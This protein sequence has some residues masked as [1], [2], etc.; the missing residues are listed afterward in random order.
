VSR[1]G[2]SAAILGGLVY[3]CGGSVDH[4]VVGRVDVFD[5]FESAWRQVV[6]LQVPRQGASAC[7]VNHRLYICGGWDAGDS[8]LSSVEGL[9]GGTEEAWCLEPFQLMQARSWFGSGVLNNELYFCGGQSKHDPLNSAERLNLQTGRQEKLPAMRECRSAPGSAAIAGPN[10]PC[11]V[12]AG[13]WDQHRQNLRTVELFDPRE[14]VWTSIVPLLS[15]RFGAAACSVE[16]GLV[17]LGGYED[18]DI[19]A[20]LNTTERFSPSEQRWN[21]L[22]PMLFARSGAVAVAGFCS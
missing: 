3:F 16:G 8:P 22:S 5:P 17:V 14:G 13:G 10:G 12:V 19:D 6:S 20:C 15:R 1:G 11:L 4:K 2:A 21:R 9:R 7:V 18:D